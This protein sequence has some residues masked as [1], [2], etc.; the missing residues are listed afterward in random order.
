MPLSRRTLLNL[1]P[2]AALFTSLPNGAAQTSP[3]ESPVPAGFPAQDPEIV[4]T[5]VIAA[6]SDIERVRSY[7]EARPALAKATWDWGFGDWESALGGASHMGNR[8]IA[9]LLIANGATPTIFSAAML[10]QLDVVRT[11]IS[12]APGCQRIRGPHGITLLAHAKAGGPQAAEVVKFL[13]SLGDA[14]P[15][16]TNESISEADQAAVT[17]TYAF[18]AS[19]NERLTISATPRGLTIKRDGMVE[20]NL[21]HLGSRVFHPAGAEAVRVRF[22]LAPKATVLTVEDGTMRVT[23]RRP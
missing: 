5:V 1:C 11:F 17:G 14:D 19:S 13:E 8:E 10:G 20:R 21:F 16:Y 4:R 3:S 7:I 15:R 2:A 23:A 12:A 6:H 22:E 9:L 18:G